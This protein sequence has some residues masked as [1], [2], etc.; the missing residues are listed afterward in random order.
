AKG[1]KGSGSPP[2]FGPPAPLRRWNL[3]LEIAN[4]PGGGFPRTPTQP[5]HCVLVFLAEI[6]LVESGACAI[7][8]FRSATPS[9]SAGSV[10]AQRERTFRSPRPCFASRTRKSL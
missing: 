10:R 8:R 5:L 6:V 3:G 1:S 7:V 9:Q 2:T 4:E